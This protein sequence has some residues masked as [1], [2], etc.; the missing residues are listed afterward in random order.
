MLHGP[1]LRPRETTDVVRLH[2]FS[3]VQLTSQNRGVLERKISH[4]I[5]QRTDY[6]SDN[7]YRAN[8]I[9]FFHG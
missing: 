1:L 3:K 9:I 8:T 2:D 5:S 4:D 7:Y 6:Y